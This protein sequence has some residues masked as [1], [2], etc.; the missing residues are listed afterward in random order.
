MKQQFNLHLVSD[1]SSATLSHF[2]KSALSQMPELAAQKHTWLMIKNDVALEK[3]ISSIKKNPGVVLYIISDSEL[4]DKLKAFCLSQ[5]LPCIGI[6]GKFIKEMCGYFGVE[7]GSY[8]ERLDEDY[9]DKV[10]AIEYTLNHDDGQQNHDLEKADIILVGVSRT[11]KSPTCIYLAYN[12]Y[13]AANIPFIYGHQLP[14]SLFHVKEPLVVGL[15]I[16]PEYL[17]EIRQNRLL[18]FDGK[19]ENYTDEEQVILECREARKL[20]TKHNWPVIDITNRS[21]E[22]T[23]GNIIKLY[24][25]RKKKLGQNLVDFLQRS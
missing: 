20:F 6:L 8:S 14:E 24:L 2:A 12:G 3:C 19:I 1:G 21:I 17:I 18:S 5:Q 4:R 7:A 16:N 22:E 13:R 15:Y 23:A 10:A 25:K 11:S 9:Y